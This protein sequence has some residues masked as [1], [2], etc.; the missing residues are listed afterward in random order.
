[1]SDLSMSDLVLLDLAGIK[2]QVKAN[3]EEF[4]ASVEWLRAKLKIATFSRDTLYFLRQLSSYVNLDG[5]DGMLAGIEQE[6]ITRLI[7]EQITEEKAWREAEA[8]S[9]KEAVS[10]ETDEEEDPLGGA[11]RQ[12]KAIPVELK[13]F[14]AQEREGINAIAAYHSVLYGALPAVSAFRE[15]YLPAKLLSAAEAD[16]FLRSAALRFLSASDFEQ[17]GVDILRHQAEVISLTMTKVTAEQK[18]KLTG[19][20]ILYPAIEQPLTAEEGLGRW[21]KYT[22]VIALTSLGT[23]ES[24]PVRHMVEKILVAREKKPVWM[25]PDP[26]FKQEPDVVI[27]DREFPSS[28]P[29]SIAS[30]LHQIITSRTASGT[31]PGDVWK[32]AIFVLTCMISYNP[33]TVR[34]AKHITADINSLEGAALIARRMERGEGL[35]GR[36]EIEADAWIKSDTIGKIYHEQQ[37]LLGQTVDGKTRYKISGADSLQLVT[38][39]IRM[40]LAEKVSPSYHH[41][42]EVLRKEGKIAGTADNFRKRYKRACEILSIPFNMDNV[43]QYIKKRR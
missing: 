17:L 34:T 16:A 19:N 39:V 1:M 5:R 30:E 29:A 8:A 42:Y 38:E 12:P 3:E 15:R 22:A 18:E 7:K 6:W 43:V 2:E 9:G 26:F 23:T 33:V 25:F 31:I 35:C 32:R 40:Y 4:I 11:S 37:S 27:Q 36:I 24:K 21:Y 13:L 14:S 10:G 20:I 28:F 41:A